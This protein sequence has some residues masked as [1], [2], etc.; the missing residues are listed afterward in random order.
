[1]LTLNK[2]QSPLYRTPDDL[3]SSPFTQVLE[4]LFILT[5]PRNLSHVHHFRNIGGLS[6]L[7]YLNRTLPT[8]VL[9]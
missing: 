8:A 5:S 7:L 4:L 6:C 9:T 1:M 2:S 3:R